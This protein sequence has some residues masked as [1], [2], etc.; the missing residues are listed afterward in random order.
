M[1]NRMYVGISATL[2]YLVGAI[3]ICKPLCST[4]ARETK[5]KNTQNL[6]QDFTG[7]SGTVREQRGTRQF[8][9]KCAKYA[10]RWLNN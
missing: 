9:F 2:D 3:R 7:F 1:E 5:F 6:L 8:V 4:Q 10:S